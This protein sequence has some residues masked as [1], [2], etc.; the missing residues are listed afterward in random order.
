MARR[1]IYMY[2]LSVCIRQLASSTAF[3]TLA[4]CCERTLSL[5]ST[6]CATDRYCTKIN[7]SHPQKCTT[8]RLVKA[9]QRRTHS[10][11][12]DKTL[13]CCRE[14]RWTIMQTQETFEAAAPAVW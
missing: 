5:A 13:L 9:V 2:F 4:L 6:F 10:Q 8:R 12:G 7:R 3:G 14:S 1:P 11:R